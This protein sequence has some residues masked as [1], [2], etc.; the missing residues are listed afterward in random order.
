MPAPADRKYLDSHEWHKLED[1]G[2]VTIGISEFAVDELTDITYLEIANQD[3]E[4]KAGEAFGEIE[5]V[6][7]T[8][9]LYCGIDGTV[10]AVN[11][12]A[13]DDPETINRDCFGE[14]WMIRVQ[15]ADAAQLEGLM[16]AAA[17]ESN[18]G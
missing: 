18:H 17:Y 7:A 13:V 4:I 6:K 15:P 9:D 3:G 1:D 8:S 11:Q 10:V 12:A 14:G 5:S 2:T 16:D